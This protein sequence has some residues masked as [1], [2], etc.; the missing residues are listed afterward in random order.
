MVHYTYTV[1][2][3]YLT[4]ITLG[5][6][7]SI[8]HT[9]IFFLIF[10]IIDFDISRKVSPVVTIAWNVKTNIFNLSSTELYPEL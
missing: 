8:R 9:E 6:I 3:A 5:K 7:F 10:P 2:Y 4:L 1:N